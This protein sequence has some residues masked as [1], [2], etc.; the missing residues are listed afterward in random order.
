MKFMP[1]FF[2]KAQLMKLFLCFPDPHFKA[3]KH[4][5]RIVSAT[6]GAE[7]AYVM[8][9]GGIIYTITDVRDLH[10]WMAG[11]FSSCESFER[12]TDEETEA[13]RCVV[14]MREATEEG[15]KVERNQG[16]KLVACF[17]RLEDPPWPE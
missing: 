5:A 2:R 14:I 1:N 15:K 13:D 8:R 7:Y 11:H 4:K 12:L 6:L 17:R 9:P 3:R 10:E 16:L